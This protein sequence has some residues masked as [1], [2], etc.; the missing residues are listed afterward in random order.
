MCKNI[1]H[2]NFNIEFMRFLYEPK[3]IGFVQNFYKLMKPCKFV[4]P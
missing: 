3:K 1:F 2:I 4:M